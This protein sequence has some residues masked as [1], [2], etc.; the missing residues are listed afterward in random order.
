MSETWL[1]ER[2]YDP[3]DALYYSLKHDGFLHTLV[4][5][6]PSKVCEHRIEEKK[7]A[8]KKGRM[9][10]WNKQF[11]LVPEAFLGSEPKS[12]EID[13]KVLL[14]EGVYLCY[15]GKN[16]QHL[17]QSV[18]LSARKVAENKRHT[19]F[20]WWYS[21]MLYVLVFNNQNLQFANG[22]EV[23]NASEVAYFILSAAQECGIHQEKFVIV[24]DAQE[25]AMQ[26]LDVV[27]EKLGLEVDAVNRSL[28]YGNYF[29]SPYQIL[30]GY[31]YQMPQCALPEAY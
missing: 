3:T 19:V 20:F 9:V 6:S 14:D 16:R 27:L 31:L 23:Q 25:D 7:G 4:F 5:D 22:F 18:Y 11:T 21:G 26:E 2:Q 30:S 10:L 8:E 13:T 1:Y 28:L 29:N 12:L 24:G 15:K 17:F